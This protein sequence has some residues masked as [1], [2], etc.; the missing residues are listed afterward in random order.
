MISQSALAQC[1]PKSTMIPAFQIR[2]DVKCFHGAVPDSVTLDTFKV[3]AVICAIENIEWNYPFAAAGTYQLQFWLDNTVD[4]TLSICVTTQCTDQGTL[5][6]F[7]GGFSADGVT[8]GTCDDTV[9]FP[10]GSSAILADI[11]TPVQLSSF[12]ATAQ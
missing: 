2:G 7:T 11:V 10:T 5:M 4:H 6:T 12:T 3:D 9:P 8:P 1:N